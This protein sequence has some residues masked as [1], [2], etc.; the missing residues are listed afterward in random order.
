MVLSRS[1]RP[2]PD[3]ALIAK[4][5]GQGLSD[6]DVRCVELAKE[7]LLGKQVWRDYGVSEAADFTGAPVQALE[8]EERAMTRVFGQL[9][10]TITWRQA[11]ARAAELLFGG[12]N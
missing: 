1:A 4:P 11:K 8:V 10:A 6:V 12:V 9:G 3:V 2:V 7:C 5:A